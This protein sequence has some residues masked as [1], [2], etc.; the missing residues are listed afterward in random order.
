MM[1]L[2]VRSLLFNLGFYGFTVVTVI[3]RF[4]PGS[5]A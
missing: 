5:S 4:T 2:W 3:G 1:V